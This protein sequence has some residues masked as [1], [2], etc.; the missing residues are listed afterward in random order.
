MGGRISLL[1]SGTQERKQVED[2]EAV[3]VAIHLIT[4]EPIDSPWQ[5][6]KHTLH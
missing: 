1:G 3:G 5:L 6:Y 2:D 4:S